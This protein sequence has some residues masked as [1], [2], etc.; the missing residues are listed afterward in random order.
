MSEPYSSYPAI[1]GP[2]SLLGGIAGVEYLER[3]PYALPAVFN[4]FLLIIC[5]TM[6]AF[7]LGEV[8]KQSS[9]RGG[10][11]TYYIDRR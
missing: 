4:G 10:E 2:N 3:Y 5:A 11:N 8:L 9:I 6:V 7:G 1:F